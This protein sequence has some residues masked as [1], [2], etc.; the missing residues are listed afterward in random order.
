MNTSAQPRPRAD[1]PTLVIHWGLVLALTF[2]VATGW[3]IASLLDPV[4]LRWVEALLIQGNV[5]HWHFVSATL[6]VALVVGYGVFLWR[7]GLAGRLSLRLASL[8]HPDR[9]TRWKAINKLVYWI[10]FALLGLAALTGFL[11]YFLPGLLPTNA[12][13]TAH[14]WLSWA[15]VFYVLLHVAAQLLQGGIRQ[16]LKMVTPRMAY[17]IGGALALSAGAAGAAVAFLADASSMRVLTVPKLAQPPL[18]DGRGDDEAWRRAPAVTVHTS[19]GFNLAGGEVDVEVS[20]VHDGRRAYFRF[21]WADATRSQ[22]HI[23][24]IKTAQGWKLLQS[25]YGV[26]DENDYYEDKFAVM[27]ARSPVAGGDTVRLGPQPL[28]GKPGPDHGLGLHAATDGSL[29]DVWHW[30]SVRTGAFQQMDDNHFGAPLPAKAGRYT[31]GYTQDPKTGGGYEQN[32][33]KIAD[34]D[35]VR[36]RWLPR[37]L[38]AQQAKMGRFDPDPA[39]SHAGSYAMRMNEVV[40]WT[41]ERDAAL[42]VGTVIPSVVW[43]QPF[44]G[45]RG[46]VSAVA[47]WADGFWTLET[48]RALDTGSPFDQPIATGMFMWVAVFD[49]NQVRHTRHVHPLKLVLE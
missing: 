19:R 31:G 9:D 8:R 32:F 5:V 42:P 2:S 12:T 11:L 29:A 49:H 26:N 36:V 34:S 37:D 23:P 25:N 24:L 6:L 38:A 45:D 48:S 22:Q 28:P 21:R 39:S 43:D 40:K 46:D 30:K 16:L 41:P 3:R 17:G 7:M 10:S 47:Q 20:A 14:R 35:L 15:F 27:L 18:L 13:V 44:S 33:E 1:W 4:W